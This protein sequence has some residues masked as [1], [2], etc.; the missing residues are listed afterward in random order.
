MISEALPPELT[1]RATGLG[2]WKWTVDADLDA[3]ME[4]K[5]MCGGRT[6]GDCGRDGS[7]CRRAGAGL[8]G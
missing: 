2:G 8:G 6:I 7:A 4:T 3:D 5:G 1:R